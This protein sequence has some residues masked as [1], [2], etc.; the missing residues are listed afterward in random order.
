[1]KLV[2]ILIFVNSVTSERL[3][4]EM[5]PTVSFLQRA[6]LGARCQG[7]P[8]VVNVLLLLLLLGVVTVSKKGS[9][10]A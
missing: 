1:M 6:R 3:G 10:L 8:Y 4:V 7:T 5:P 9:N 2:T